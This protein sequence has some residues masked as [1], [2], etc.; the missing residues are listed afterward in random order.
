MLNKT[1]S[2]TTN[3][4]VPFN[5]PFSG[6]RGFIPNN[7][8]SHTTYCG[9][10]AQPPP[11]PPPPHPPPSM[12]F[13]PMM[14]HPSAPYYPQPQFMTRPPQPPY[15]SMPTPPGVP[16]STYDPYL[17]QQTRPPVPGYSPM[18][19][20]LNG[21][22]QSRQLYSHQAQLSNQQVTT[23]SKQSHHRQ[24]QEYYFIMCPFF[25]SYFTLKKDISYLFIYDL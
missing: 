7:N 11:P 6:Q 12:P 22:H 9:H 14:M 17:I 10:M 16:P 18:M 5:G 15:P 21:P 4:S 3:P 19:P 24:Y 23:F 20:P 2:N 1:N 25:L 8:A 13:P